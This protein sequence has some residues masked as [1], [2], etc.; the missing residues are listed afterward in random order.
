M[1]HILWTIAGIAVI[2]AVVSIAFADTGEKPA[3]KKLTGEQL[4]AMNCARCHTERYPTERTD[5]QWKTIML[6]M[7]T[8]AR[9]PADDAKK[10]LQYLQDNN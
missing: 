3:K 7:R 8:R 6:H 10:I 5:A 4:F 1:K 2:S 9:L